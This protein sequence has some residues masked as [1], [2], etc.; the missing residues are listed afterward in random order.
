LTLEDGYYFQPIS[1]EDEFGEI[2]VVIWEVRNGETGTAIWKLIDSRSGYACN[3]GKVY[4]YHINLG[5]TPGIITP[6]RKFGQFRP[7]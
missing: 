6:F 2:N 4:L 7:W 3:L 5:Y 1:E